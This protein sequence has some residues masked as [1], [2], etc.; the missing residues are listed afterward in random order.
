MWW[1]RVNRPWPHVC[2]RHH[3]FHYR[4]FVGSLYRWISRISYSAQALLKSC[5]I[6]NQLNVRV[7]LCCQFWAAYVPCDAQHRDAVQL[8]FEQ[9]DLIQRLT[10]K[11]HPQLTLCTSA[12]GKQ[13]HGHQESTVICTKSNT[14]QVQP[15]LKCV[16]F[17]TATWKGLM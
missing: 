1:Q 17:R 6:F 14:F 2:H 5:M 8:T 13:P 4:I 10:E 3:W 16:R 12:E 15:Y 7:I 9:I 11:Y